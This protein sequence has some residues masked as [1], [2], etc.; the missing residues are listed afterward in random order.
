MPAL[1]DRVDLLVRL[2]NVRQVAA[3][4]A[5]QKGIARIREVRMQR[6]RH[7]VAQAARI[8]TV[9]RVGFAR[10]QRREDTARG[11]VNSQIDAIAETPSAAAQGLVIG[12]GVMQSSLCEPTLTNSRPF[13]SKTNCL[14]GC[15]L[16]SSF[17][18]RAM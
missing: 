17:C 1:L 3:V 2:E 16:S 6:Q 18:R 7:R 13:L 14:N 9:R 15:A 8:D 5:L 12:A 10:L 11:G 4:L